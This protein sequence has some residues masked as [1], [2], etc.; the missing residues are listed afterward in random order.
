M[1]AENYGMVKTVFQQEAFSHEK[2]FDW[3]HC[4]K[5]G[6]TSTES[7]KHSGP[8]TSSR[9]DEVIANVHDLVRADQRITTREVAEKQ[10]ISFG[11]CK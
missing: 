2:V 7:D 9:N 1:E 8:P 6:P 10:G 5:D 3:F 11:S 4:F